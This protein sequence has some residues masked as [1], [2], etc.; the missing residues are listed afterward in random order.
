MR[1]SAL[2]NDEL[3]EG[4]VFA[5]RNEALIEVRDLATFRVQPNKAKPKKVFLDCH[6][7]GYSPPD[8]IPI[9]GGCPKCGG[10]SWDRFALARNL[11]P[12]H[13]L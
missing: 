2:V 11:V 9:D 5:D 8:G 12:A 7:C 6:Y 13:M 10:S 1:S 3:T 4:Y